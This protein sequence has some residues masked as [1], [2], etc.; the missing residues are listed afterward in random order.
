MLLQLPG[1]R[2][3]ALRIRPLSSAPLLPPAL[4]VV[5]SRIIA[6]GAALAAASLYYLLSTESEAGVV[7]DMCGVFEAGGAEGWDAGFFNDARALVERPVV[8]ANLASILRPSVVD[9][10]AIIVG[11]GGTGKST[12]VRKA[13][14]AL[15]AEGAG[16][17]GAGVVYFTT[18]ELR[19]D[20]SQ[21]LARAVGYRTPIDFIDRMRRYITGEI[22]EQAA[23]PLQRYEPRAS[24]SPLSRLLMSAAKLHKARHGTAPTLVLDAMDV[25]AKND[26]AFFGEVQGFA[27]ACADGGILRIVFIFSD[28]DALPL[29][30]SSSRV[31]LRQGPD[32]R[33]GRHQR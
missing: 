11:P 20:F 9:K 33:G 4:V 29:L 3:S 31:A 2:A 16:G 28:G 6:G 12:A 7:S 27:K 19:A 25:I 30:L 24:W 18:R 21:D 22:K 10:Y 32:L 13:V 1:M 14:H 8:E 23:P 5:R 26:A 17:A 15:I